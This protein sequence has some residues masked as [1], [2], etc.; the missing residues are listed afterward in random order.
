MTLSAGTKDNKFKG[1]AMD[2]KR[3]WAA[4]V[5]SATI[6]WRNWH[7]KMLSGGLFRHATGGKAIFVNQLRQKDLRY[8][9]CRRSTLQSTTQMLEN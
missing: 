5:L 2:I 9:H 8:H 1:Y 3:I 6:F 4:N 7:K